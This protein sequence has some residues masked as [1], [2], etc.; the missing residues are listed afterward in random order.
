MN[1]NSKHQI[2]YNNITDLFEQTH[3][4][5]WF[6]YPPNPKNTSNSHISSQQTKI[7]D[8]SKHQIN[9]NVSD[10]ISTNTLQL[11]IEISHKTKKSLPIGIHFHLKNSQILGRRLLIALPFHNNNSSNFDKLQ[12]ITHRMFA[13]DNCSILLPKRK[14]RT[15]QKSDKF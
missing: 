14:C 7:N 8:N 3:H 9:K 15:P 6:K 5:C 10:L 13:G 11:L 2:S 12:W 1:D 4:N